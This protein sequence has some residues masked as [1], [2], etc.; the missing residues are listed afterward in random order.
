[1]DLFSH[2]KMVLLT[3]YSMAAS[4]PLSLKI[5]TVL[6][7]L[8]LKDLRNTQDKACTGVKHGPLLHLKV[9]IIVSERGHLDH[10]GN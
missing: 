3:K 9:S 8:R 6:F 4:V 1:M 2:I 7:P 10:T 5:L